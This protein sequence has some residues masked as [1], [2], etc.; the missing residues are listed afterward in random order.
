MMQPPRQ[1]LAMFPRWMSQS[2]SSAPAMIASKPCAYATTFDAYSAART[3][4]SKP[5]PAVPSSGRVSTTP[6]TASRCAGLLETARAKTASAM[7][8]T[9][10]PRPTAFW[11]VQTPVPFDPAWS[12]MTSTSGSPVSASRWR[13]TS[14]VISMRYDS[15][16]PSFHA[17][18]MSAIASVSCPPTR[19]RR[20]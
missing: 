20:S 11:T 4:S 17:A 14:A 1:I 3:S 19:R 18:K 12:T 2:Y 8:P 7:P 9:G 15:R 5:S 16:S 10:M 13:S 6:R